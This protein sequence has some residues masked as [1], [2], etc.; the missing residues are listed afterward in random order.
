M[1]GS[2]SC[3]VMPPPLGALPPELKSWQPLRHGGHRPPSLCSGKSPGRRAARHSPRTAQRARAEHTSL[4]SPLGAG[5][6]QFALG[7]AGRPRPPRISATG[8]ATPGVPTPAPIF[9]TVSSW[10]G[11]LFLSQ[12]GGRGTAATIHGSAGGIYSAQAT[13]WR[14]DWA[15]AARGLG[16]ANRSAD[17]R[18]RL[19]GFEVHARAGADREDVHRQRR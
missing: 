8:L 6:R 7:S 10:R 18:L 2:L 14:S 1:H 12:G 4:C 11:T 16:R 17:S 3:G 13:T 5:N 9:L 15:P 19:R